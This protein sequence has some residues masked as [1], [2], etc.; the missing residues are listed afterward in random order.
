MMRKYLDG[1]ATEPDGRANAQWGPSETTPLLRECERMTVDHY[2][3]IF[4]VIHICQPTQKAIYKTPFG[5]LVTFKNSTVVVME[6]LIKSLF[7]HILSLIHDSLFHT[8]KSQYSVL[9]K[10]LYLVV[11]FVAV[12]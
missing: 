4:F 10:S 8:T 6:L 3:R 9:Q 1:G 7:A 12:F 2:A 5:N 11:I